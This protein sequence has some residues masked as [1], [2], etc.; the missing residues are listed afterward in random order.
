MN[1]SD[2]AKLLGIHA[3]MGSKLLKGSRRGQV[4]SLEFDYNNL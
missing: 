3:S 1:G 2:I 4:S